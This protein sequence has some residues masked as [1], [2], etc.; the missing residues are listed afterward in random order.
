MDLIHARRQDLR[1][2]L[3][4]DEVLEPEELTTMID[5][6]GTEEAREYKIK[7]LDGTEA[8]VLAA[9]VSLAPDPGW[10]AI[11]V[12]MTTRKAAE[13]EAQHLALHDPLTGLSNRRLL[14]D[15]LE[16]A[17][18]QARRSGAPLAVLFCDLDRFKALNDEFG[19]AAGDHAL[20]TVAER[21]REQSRDSDT[22]ARVGGDEF[23]VVLEEL[24][25]PVDAARVAERIRRA[26]AQP[27]EYNGHQLQLTCSLGI[28]FASEKDPDTASLLGRA[29]DAMYEAKQ[30]GRDQVGGIDL[31]DLEPTSRS[32][33]RRWLERELNAALVDDGLELAF[34]PVIDLRS[35]EAVAVEALLRWTVDGTQIS[36]ERAIAVAEESG[37]IM[38][39]SDWVIAEA[40]RRF[41]AW[42]VPASGADAACR[43][44][45]EGAHQRFGPRP[46]R[47]PIRRAGARRDLSR[48]VRPHR[49]LPRGH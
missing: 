6:F 33:E 49:C 27:I 29:D 7:R 39:V 28:A 35:G 42:R 37:L 10:M 3:P 4:V 31:E 36:T 40:S 34:Q 46:R 8:Y 22:V 14:H 44:A 21:L 30:L 23:I 45:V 18:A 38:R 48:R 16:H 32:S 41:S 43:R 1:T 2:G 47:R 5:S 17:L 24:S 20:Q 15:R 9:A 25:D 13:Q 26:V 11:A 19:H 12:D